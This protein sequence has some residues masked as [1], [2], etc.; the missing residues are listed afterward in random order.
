[1]IDLHGPPWLTAPDAIAICHALAPLA[2]LFVEEP[3]A[4]EDMDGYRRLRAATACRSPPASAC[5]GCTASRRCCP[6]T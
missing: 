3:L 1:M 2:P 6:R 4:P 5:A